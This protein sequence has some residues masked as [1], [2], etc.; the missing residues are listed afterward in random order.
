MIIKTSKFLFAVLLIVSFT[1]CSAVI[2]EV[3]NDSKFSDGDYLFVMYKSYESKISAYGVM[4]IYYMSSDSTVSGSY[5]FDMNKNSVLHSDKGGIIGKA[6]WNTGEAKL[7][8]G[9]SF[10]GNVE[11]TLRKNIDIIE[12]EW[13]SGYSGGKIY[14]FKKNKW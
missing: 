3:V 8:F 10:Y 2:N 4:S 11:V 14:A 13:S 12:G 1:S 7:R 6:N 5:T 9:N